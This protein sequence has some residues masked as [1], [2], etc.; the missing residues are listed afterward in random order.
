[1]IYVIIILLAIAIIALNLKSVSANS[2]EVVIVKGLGKPKYLT[3]GST[4]IW[5]FFQKVTDTIPLTETP[6]NVVGG[7]STSDGL[8]L[9]ITVVG[10][11]KPIAENI[12]SGVDI[13]K[14][15]ETFL[16]A[17]TTISSTLNIDTVGDMEKIQNDLK[18]L[19]NV[20]GVTLDFS[21]TGLNETS[22]ILKELRQSNLQERLTKARLKQQAS[23][24]EI[25][26]Q[27]ERDRTE[28]EKAM[29]EREK[30]LAS[31]RNSQKNENEKKEILQKKELDDL[32]ATHANEAAKTKAE[33][34]KELANIQKDAALAR[35]EAD[36]IY[37]KKMTESKK[38]VLDIEIANTKKQQLL[39]EEKSKI[40]TARIKT[41]SDNEAY[42]Q[43]TEAKSLAEA[44][45]IQVEAER[46]KQEMQAV[47]DLRKGEVEAEIIEKKGQAK[48]NAKR[49]LL[50]AESNDMVQKAQ[51]YSQYNDTAQKAMILDKL[52]VIT[53]NIGGSL[54]KIDKM[55]IYS[56]DGKG[57]EQ[58]TGQVSAMLQQSI[59]VVEGVT[60]LNLVK[61]EKEEK[62]K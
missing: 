18:E 58:V 19:V 46:Y 34:D 32:R 60:G 16:R 14:V 49:A 5:R 59:D 1:M 56:N 62:G 2:S 50:E 22:G 7:G 4:L 8:S 52:P 57:A 3:G 29:F 47:A 55:N 10:K 26:M 9:S 30:I 21:V 53:K 11:V 25:N 45:K 54:Q 15:R 28:E 33:R 12:E 20:E 38:E 43:E 17:L 41:A 6:F 13:Q 44:M 42:R 40:E 51:A 39:E 23:E 48:A 61:K 24:H 35:A 31:M 36:S 27:R 37:Q